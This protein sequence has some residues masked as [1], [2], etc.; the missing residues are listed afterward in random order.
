M[1]FNNYRGISL[2]PTCYKVLANVIQARL[3][4][5]AED[6]LGDYQGGFRRNRSTSDQMFTVRQMMEKMW[7]HGQVMHQLFE[8][9]KKAYDFIKKSKMY[10]ILVLLGVPKKL[11]GLIRVCLNGSRGRVRVGRNASEPFE[12]HDGVFI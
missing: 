11:V 10:Q 9:F 3:T 2:L 12:I 6:I 5:F 1:N 8:D 4:P 7:E